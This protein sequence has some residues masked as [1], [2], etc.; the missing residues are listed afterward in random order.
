MSLEHRGTPLR[1]RLEAAIVARRYYLDNRQKSEIADELGISR[2][3]VAR[4]LDEARAQGIVQIHIEMPAEVDLH[5]GEKLARHY[6]IPRA[7]VVTTTDP[8]PDV[9][10]P[11]IGQACA[12]LLQSSLDADDVLGISWGTSLTN[13]VDAVSALPACD[14]VQ[15][16]GGLPSVDL[17][18]NGVELLRRLA[19]KTRGR[20]WALHA[21][22]LMRSA[23][24]A[25][26]LR[27]EPGIAATLDRYSDLTVALVGV[28][29]W[30][31]P[32]STLYAQIEEPERRELLERGATA[33]MCAFV[34][35]NT[36][37]P[38]PSPVTERAVGIS[39]SELR[40][41]PEV[42]AVAGGSDKLESIRAVLASGIPHT[43]V[44][45]SIT[46]SALLTPLG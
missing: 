24:V 25:D 17:N 27:A 9:V 13:V 36:G 18:V 45:D 22:L 28:G 38:L 30:S 14:L 19:Q 1:A 40:A 32:K 35:D 12:E 33:D 39:M 16:V 7:I 43:L 2:F 3:K 5:L 34:L 29:S 46:G 6:G 31:P 44:T 37:R 11:L 4:L 15:L 23:A 41:V 42:I 26:E 21:P 8:S 20:T 10:G